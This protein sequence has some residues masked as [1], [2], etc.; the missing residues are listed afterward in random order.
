MGALDPCG[1]PSL[2]LPPPP[3]P[4]HTQTYTTYPTKETTAPKQSEIFEHHVI[5]LLICESCLQIRLPPSAFATPR[6]ICNHSCTMYHV[7][8][9]SAVVA[10]HLKL[11]EPAASCVQLSRTQLLLITPD[12]VDP[13]G[14]SVR[15]LW[16]KIQV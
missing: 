3:P 15:E 5:N 16:F 11:K 8:H 6:I 12:L 13:S 2:I 4:T 14:K 7:P 1:S 10:S 9:K